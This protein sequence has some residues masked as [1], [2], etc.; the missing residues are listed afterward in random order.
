MDVH[1]LYHFGSNVL[2]SLIHPVNWIVN[3][4]K[5][6]KSFL[7]TANSGRAYSCSLKKFVENKPT[8]DEL[9]QL[10]KEGGRLSFEL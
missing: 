10:L 7:L 2:K 8:G 5:A 3:S 9:K 4:K 1:N 6:K